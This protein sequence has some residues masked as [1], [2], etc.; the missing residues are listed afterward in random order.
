MIDH[1]NC[2]DNKNEYKS[3][4]TPSSIENLF[5]KAYDDLIDILDT[6]VPFRQEALLVAD[7]TRLYIQNLFNLTENDFRNIMRQNTAL[8]A[9]AARIARQGKNPDFLLRQKLLEQDQLSKI[10]QRYREH[11]GAL[12]CIL[13][14]KATAALVHH[15]IHLQPSIDLPLQL[16]GC[17]FGSGTGILSVAGSIPFVHK[18]KALAMHS[19]EQSQVPREDAQKIVELLMHKSK[20]KNQ[21]Q[22]H[23]HSSDVTSEEPYKLVNESIKCSGPLAL[24]ISETFGHRSQ[25]PIVTGNGSTFTFTTPTGVTPYSFEQEEKYDPLPKVL[26]HSCR[27]FDLFIKKIETG[28][29]VAFPDII[30][31]RVIIDGAVSAILAPDGNWRKLHEIGQPYDMLPTCT[32]SRWH[33]EELSQPYKKQLSFKTSK[34]KIFKK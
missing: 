32:P 18:A 2:R 1:R 21:L 13:D 10:F 20:Y 11:L 29:I 7:F 15:I 9:K 16:T 24:W 28:H 12:D 31:P 14:A 25:K 6:Q 3:M 34:K 26:Y 19:F 30:R 27:N 33:F 4:T 23:M 5:V 17:E 22:F 8:N